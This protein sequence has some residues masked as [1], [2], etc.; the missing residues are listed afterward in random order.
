MLFRAFKSTMK[1]VKRRYNL[2]PTPNLNKARLRA[3]YLRMR[4]GKTGG[5][6]KGLASFKKPCQLNAN[7][8]NKRVHGQAMPGMRLYI[9]YLPEFNK[10]Y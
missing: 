1:P 4:R 9:P 2:A 6:G 3:T 7:K 8:V 10:K 5:P